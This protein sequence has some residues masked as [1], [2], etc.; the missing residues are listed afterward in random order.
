MTYIFNLGLRNQLAVVNER[1]VNFKEMSAS[2]YDPQSCV[3]KQGWDGCFKIVSGHTYPC[4]IKYFW[5]YA[6]F[7][8]NLKQGILYKASDV[9]FNIISATFAK[10]KDCEVYKVTPNVYVLKQIQHVSVDT[11]NLFKIP[12]LGKMNV[13]VHIKMKTIVITM[14]K[15]EESEEF[16]QKA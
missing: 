15:E 2:Y 5:I 12:N 10:A 16:L 6:S 7:E 4:L 9:H 11:S 13:S 14:A 3:S 8:L 1:V